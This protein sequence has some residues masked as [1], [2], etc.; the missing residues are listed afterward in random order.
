MITLG[1]TDYQLIRYPAGELEVRLSDRALIEIATK[2][3]VDVVARIDW[4]SLIVELL[5]LIDAI[6]SCRKSFRV[7]LPYL[8]YGR[9]DRQFVPGGSFGLDVFCTL[10]SDVEVVTL[11]AHSS[12]AGDCL[13]VV[14]VDPMSFIEQAVKDFNPEIILFPD[15]GA[16]TRYACAGLHTVQASKTRDAVTGKFIGFTVPEIPEQNILIVDDLCDGGGTF[17]GLADLLPKKRLGLYVTHGIFSQGLEKLLERFGH[18]YTTDSFREWT[19]T[20]KVT[21]Y[22]CLQLLLDS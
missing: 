21:I 4:A 5:H 1:S 12:V 16:A 11:D 9:N 8:P 19:P 14:N 13:H 18:I 10:L 22:S 17:I 7:I 2:S 6:R 3:S 20:P 15:A